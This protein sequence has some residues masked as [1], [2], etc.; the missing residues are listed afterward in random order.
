MYLCGPPGMTD[1][2]LDALRG[3]GVHRRRIHHE[4]FA[5]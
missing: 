5:F 3:A 4:T 2:A 1:A